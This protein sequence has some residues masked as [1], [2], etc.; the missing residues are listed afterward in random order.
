MCIRDRVYAAPDAPQPLLV[1]GDKYCHRQ[2]PQRYGSYQPDRVAPRVMSGYHDDRAVGH[3]ER[4]AERSRGEV[5][6]VRA[7]GIEEHVDREP[8][9]YTHLRAHETVLDL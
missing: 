4:E 1:Q 2:G 6:D 5:E 9:S 8:V 7:P 3:G